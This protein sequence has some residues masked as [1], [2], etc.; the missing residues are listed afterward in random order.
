MEL[1]EH[2]PMEGFC[3]AHSWLNTK[4]SWVP[5]AL[6]LLWFSAMLLLSV[7]LLCFGPT[8]LMLVSLLFFLLHLCSSGDKTDYQQWSLFDFTEWCRC[9]PS[10]Y[11]LPKPCLTSVES[12]ERAAVFTLHIDILHQFKVW[13][14][15]KSNHTYWT[16]RI[17]K[18]L[19]PTHI[20]NTMV[21]NNTRALKTE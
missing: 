6:I 15:I 5:L 10:R 17:S 21:V 18:T 9:L 3:H 20:Y 11:W 4:R 14:V 19:L 7:L 8:V 1:S 2:W 12:Q 13:Q 16:S